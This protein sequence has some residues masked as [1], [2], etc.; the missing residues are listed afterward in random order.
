MHS[1]NTNLYQ[2][3]DMSHSS[4]TSSKPKRPPA[5]YNLFCSDLA[6]D[7]IEP[8]LEQDKTIHFFTRASNEWRQLGK[9]G[10][11]APWHDRAEELKRL[12]KEKEMKIRC[13]GAT[14]DLGLED[15]RQAS[16]PMGYSP[17]YFAFSADSS[18]QPANGSAT[19]EWHLNQTIPADY[20]GGGASTSNSNVEGF[21]THPIWADSPWSGAPAWLA[22]N[23]RLSNLTEYVS[24]HAYHPYHLTLDAQEF[25]DGLPYEPDTHASGHWE[26]SHAS[27]SGTNYPNQF[28]FSN[29]RYQR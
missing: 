19:M 5:A 23:D 22:S 24:P 6:N 20:N 29:Y 2:L 1:L 26:T 10:L 16:P 4:S 25:D 17:E 11:Q 28:E 3:L 8:I 13:K 9:L 15:S 12:E 18:Y 27:G 21:S 7:V 14:S